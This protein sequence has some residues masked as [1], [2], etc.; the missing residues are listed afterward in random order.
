MESQKEEKEYPDPFQDAKNAA[1]D[2]FRNM[3]PW[4]ALFVIDHPAIFM[5]V[6][7]VV[8]FL[9]F[10]FC[11]KQMLM[12]WKILKL[13][14]VAGFI[15]AHV[16]SVTLTWAMLEP[17][18][19]LAEVFVEILIALV[20]PSRRLLD[21]ILSPFYSILSTAKIVANPLL[22]IIEKQMQ[23]LL[24]AIQHVFELKAVLAHEIVMSFSLQVEE[25]F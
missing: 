21:V 1:N 19:T 11:Y 23:G 17:N 2:A 22:S 3:L 24:W 18:A 13:V 20:A 25:T 10:R 12:L 9:L 4:Y 7:A 16:T 5:S 8:L 15:S 14:L 6:L